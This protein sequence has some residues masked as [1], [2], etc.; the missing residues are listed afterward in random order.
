MK[1]KYRLSPAEI[2]QLQEIMLHEGLLPSAIQNPG[3]LTELLGKGLVR[4]E[5]GRYWPNWEAISHHSEP[6]CP[7]E[8]RGEQ[9]TSVACPKHGGPPGSASGG[10]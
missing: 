6:R 4:I 9:C 10:W 5:Y 7:Q 1:L 2:I 3:A 8:D